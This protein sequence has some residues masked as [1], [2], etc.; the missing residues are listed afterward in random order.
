MSYVPIFLLGT[1]LENIRSISIVVRPFSSGMYIQAP[2]VAIAASPP[3]TNPTLPFRSA[4]SGFMRYGITMLKMIP[5]DD[6]VAVAS[7]V[8]CARRPMLDT[9][10]SKTKA[11]APSDMEYTNA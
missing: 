9:S 4:S 3:N 8:V 1:C 2:T 5:S 6:W 10:P 7:A 11:I